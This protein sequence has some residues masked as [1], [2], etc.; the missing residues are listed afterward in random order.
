MTRRIQIKGE[1]AGYTLIWGGVEIFI[2]LGEWDE[3][4]SDVMKI[5][6]EK[7]KK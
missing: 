3:L 1:A 7:R 6:E 4:I 2:Y 5:E